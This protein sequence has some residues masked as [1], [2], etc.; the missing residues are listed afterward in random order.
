MVIAGVFVVCASLAL[1]GRASAQDGIAPSL[2]SPRVSASR[3]VA[4]VAETRAPL[5]VAPGAP[6]AT[7]LTAEQFDAFVQLIGEPKPVVWQHLQMDP[8]L[9]PLAATAADERMSRKSSGKIRT[10]VGFSIFGVG[11]A[12]GYLIMLSSFSD[13]VNCDYSGSSSCGNDISGHLWTAVLVWAASA[14]VGLGIGIPGIISMARQSEVETNAVDRYQ[15]PHG[16]L[17]PQPYYPAQSVAPSVKAF[18]VPLLSIAF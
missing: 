13:S 16:M 12:A 3:R 10:I 17:P 5:L 4:Q 1:P 2:G 18:K 8:G 7:P 15:Y 11:L 14:G 6:Q 9:V